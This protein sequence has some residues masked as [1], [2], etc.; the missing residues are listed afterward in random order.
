MGVP[1]GSNMGKAARRKAERAGEVVEVVSPAPA[2]AAHAQRSWTDIVQEVSALEELWLADGS[3]AWYRGHADE[4]WELKST[5]QLSGFLRLSRD[6]RPPAAL[7][8]HVVQH[9]E[10]P[11]G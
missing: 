2:K 4:T 3:M 7:A 11:R 6:R 9:R 5:L 1:S 10:Q 8:H